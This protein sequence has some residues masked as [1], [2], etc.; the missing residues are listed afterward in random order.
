M[1]PQGGESPGPLLR[2]IDPFDAQRLELRQRGLD[3]ISG[4]LRPQKRLNGRGAG[5][6]AGLALARELMGETGREADQAPFVEFS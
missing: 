3:G 1:G 2:C 4:G 6:G 5:Y